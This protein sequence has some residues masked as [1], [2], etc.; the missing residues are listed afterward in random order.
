MKLLIRFLSNQLV[1]ACFIIILLFSLAFNTKF[2]HIY[3]LMSPI[4][5]GLIWVLNWKCYKR[6]ASDSGSHIPLLAY[7]IVYIV[8]MITWPMALIQ[9]SKF[10][11]DD[12]DDVGE[13]NV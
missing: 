5:T 3:F 8:D 1:Y 13:K 6:I 7:V 12:A 2:L 10:L 11:L 9:T 4:A